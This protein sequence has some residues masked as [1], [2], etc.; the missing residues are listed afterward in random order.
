MSTLIGVIR[1]LI[2][3][4]A[5]L[6]IKVVTVTATGFGSYFLAGLLFSLYCW[7]ILK[8]LDYMKDYRHGQ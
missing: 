5:I 2:L 4:V 1:I 8:A 3:V 7:I 6:Q